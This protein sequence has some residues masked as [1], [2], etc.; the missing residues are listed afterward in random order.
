MAGTSPAMTAVCD[1][2]YVETALVP[3]SQKVAVDQFENRDIGKIHRSAD[4]V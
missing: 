4:E 3:L 2:N 1:A